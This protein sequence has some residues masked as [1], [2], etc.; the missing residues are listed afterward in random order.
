MRRLFAWHC[1]ACA[2][3]FSARIP[4]RE[5]YSGDRRVPDCPGCGDDSH[6]VR[7]ECE[8]QKGDDDGVEYGHP[9]D[10]R[11]GLE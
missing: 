7:V 10:Y 5:D 6:V 9:G 11:R 8:R 3:D 4:P 1:V 2:E